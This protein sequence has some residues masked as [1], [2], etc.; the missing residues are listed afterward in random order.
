MLSQMQLALSGLQTQLRYMAPMRLADASK[1]L[2]SPNAPPL[3]RGR[4]AGE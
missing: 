1:A 2:P 4:V 3:A